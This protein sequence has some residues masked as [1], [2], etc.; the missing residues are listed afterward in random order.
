MTQA[1]STR[2]DGDSWDLASSVGLT[3]TMV[4]AA[5]AG[6]SR[7]SDGSNALVNDQFAAPLVR[8]VGVDFFSRMAS[9]ELDPRD[10]DEDA[11]RNMRRFPDAMAIRTKYFDEFFL[12]ATR[13]GI[14]QAVILAS[15]LD[16]RA[17]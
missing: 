1:G 5:R 17:Y 9:G 10:L 6:A 8:A 16:S 14:R 11:A 13:A 7:A 2:F 12:D 3:A 15:G 4:A